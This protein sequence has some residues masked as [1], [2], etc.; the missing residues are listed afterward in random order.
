MTMHP[1]G[2]DREGAMKVLLG[3]VAVLS[4]LFAGFGVLICLMASESLVVGGAAAK[5]GWLGFAATV[6]GAPLLLSVVCLCS[7]S[8]K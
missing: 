6:V 1:P 5:W 2:K 4:L 8:K 3:L 7:I